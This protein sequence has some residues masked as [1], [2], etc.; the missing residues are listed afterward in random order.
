MEA[1]YA[2]LLKGNIQVIEICFIQSNNQNNE[3]VK[4][5]YQKKLEYFLQILIEQVSLLRL[6][7]G[8]YFLKKNFPP[9]TGSVLYKSTAYK[10]VN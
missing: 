9:P 3:T 5:M 10:E 8:N 7:S 6:S 1:K 2:F 4:Y